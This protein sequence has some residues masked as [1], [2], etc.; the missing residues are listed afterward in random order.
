MTESAHDFEGAFAQPKDIKLLILDVDG[1]LTDGSIN[2]HDDG[3]ET[4]RFSVRDGMGIKLWLNA[5]YPLAII[6]ARAGSALLHRVRSLGID[7]NLVIQ[8]SK[9][10]S[11]ALDVIMSKTGVEINAIAY[12]GDDWPDL[13]ALARVG[14]PMTVADAEPEVL[15]AAAFVTERNGGH[16]AV[17]QAIA[18]ILTA[19]GQYTPPA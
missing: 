2:L 6:T 10:K 8:G 1:I 14:L 5:G 19:K 17:R 7:E 18:M 9:N 11:E 16:G 12:M 4:K 13:P 15:D 3:S